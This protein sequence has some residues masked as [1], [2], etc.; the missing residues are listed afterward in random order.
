MHPI[1]GM[2]QNT[3][4]I[5]V[6]QGFGFCAFVPLKFIWRAAKWCDGLT[7]GIEKTNVNG[8]T[9]ERKH[10]RTWYCKSHAYCRYRLY[11]HDPTLTLCERGGIRYAKKSSLIFPGFLEH[12]FTVI[13]ATRV[14]PSSAIAGG[15]ASHVFSGDLA[16]DFMERCRKSSSYSRQNLYFHIRIMSASNRRNKI[17]REDH[18]LHRKVSTDLRTILQ[19]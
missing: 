5:L 6:L 18:L 15:W 2:Y 17:E 7:N 8:D 14:S 11:G 9:P 16:V 12:K 13:A 10:I 3:E 1:A 19:T 4:W